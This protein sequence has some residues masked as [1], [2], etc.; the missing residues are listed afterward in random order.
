M[1]KKLEMLCA[2]WHSF[3]AYIYV[4]REYLFTL[5]C[6]VVRTDIGWSAFKTPKQIADKY[7]LSIWQ[8]YRLIRNNRIEHHRPKG[9]KMVVVRDDPDAIVMGLWRG[10][11]GYAHHLGVDPPKIPPS[12][13]G[14]YPRLFHAAFNERLRSELDGL[15]D[16]GDSA[17]TPTD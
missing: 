14:K 4:G 7:G 13:M 10:H 17:G 15:R 12:M 16:E 5:R 9:N 8:V 11:V 6:A 3:G 1:I 2:Y